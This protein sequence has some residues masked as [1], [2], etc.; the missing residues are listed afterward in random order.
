MFY[1]HSHSQKKQKKKSLINK[2]NNN[3]I[4]NK[5]N[6]ININPEKKEVFKFTLLK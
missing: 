2:P 6:G 4:D 3:K 5:T 1:I